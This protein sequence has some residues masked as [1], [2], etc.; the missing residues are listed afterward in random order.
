MF[1][2]GKEDFV[3]LITGVHTQMQR[4]PLP[5]SNLQATVLTLPRR[6]LNAHGVRADVPHPIDEAS[7]GKLV[8]DAV[9]AK[10][11]LRNL[12]EVTVGPLEAFS[13]P[14]ATATARDAAVPQRVL[15]GRALLVANDEAALVLEQSTSEAA[16]RESNRI[17][18]G[19]QWLRLKAGSG[20]LLCTRDAG[21]AEAGKEREA[22]QVTV[23]WLRFVGTTT[24]PIE[25]QVGEKA[26]R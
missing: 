18:A 5:R 22:D 17:G 1:V 19:S 7:A 10:G 20:A 16:F 9:A 24:K 8:R 2:T 6:A 3:A 14:L 11:A 4:D 23:V 13:I 12:P 21:K 15:C 25:K 26:G